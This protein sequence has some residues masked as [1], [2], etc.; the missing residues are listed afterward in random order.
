MSDDVK[1][2]ACGAA[3]GKEELFGKLNVLGI[4]R[5]QVWGKQRIYSSKAITLPIGIAAR[6]SIKRGHGKIKLIEIIDANGK[7][8]PKRI[9]LEAV[10]EGGTK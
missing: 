6:M 8:N 10:D 3:I 1:C 5:A 4:G 9:I 7:I 2:P